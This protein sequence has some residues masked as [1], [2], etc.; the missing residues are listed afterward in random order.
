[1]RRPRRRCSVVAR[2][3]T[4]SKGGGPGESSSTGCS[5]ESRSIM[6]FSR[7][8]FSRFS[9]CAPAARQVIGARRAARGRRFPVRSREP[10][11]CR[12]PGDRRD[13]AARPPRAGAGAAAAPRPRPRAACRAAARLEPARRDDAQRCAAG[14]RGGRPLQRFLAT[15]S[16]QPVGDSMA[17]TR[18]QRSNARARF[19]DRVA[20]GGAVPAH[21]VHGRHE[22]PVLV[23][24]PRLELARVP[25][26]GHLGSQECRSRPFLGSTNRNCA[27]SAP[28]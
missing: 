19:V 8:P 7:Y 22:P 23:G 21:E 2:V 5:S 9:V 12:V 10:R 25:P 14:R 1:M 26:I 24:V 13:I 6:A 27:I 3:R 20:R 11:R 17:R 16:V 15:T 18:D 4:A 28:A